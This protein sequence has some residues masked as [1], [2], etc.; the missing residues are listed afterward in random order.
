MSGMAS[1]SGRGVRGFSS[2]PRLAF[3]LAG[4]FSAMPLAA[5]FLAINTLGRFEPGLAVQVALIVY[6]VGLP[7]VAAGIYYLAGLL[8][9]AG[10][11]DMPREVALAAAL[12]GLYSLAV[13][14][15]L[16]S[17]SRCGLKIGRQPSPVLDV[18][19]SLAT[20]G[21]HTVVLSTTLERLLDTAYSSGPS[22]VGEKAGQEPR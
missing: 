16:A 4:L 12:P 2:A 17:L 11:P 3:V 5:F 10:C 14:F 1:G 8:R 6:F 21:L 9:E 20:A 7:A 22:A 15:A 13:S 18:F 19:L